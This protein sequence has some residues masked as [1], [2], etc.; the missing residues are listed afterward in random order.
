M[1]L[2]TRRLV[3][4]RQPLDRRRA[5]TNRTSQDIFAMAL[6]LRSTAVLG[7]DLAQE[8]HTVSYNGSP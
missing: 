5:R 4:E 3:N 7:I 2:V 8:L 1:S 6:C